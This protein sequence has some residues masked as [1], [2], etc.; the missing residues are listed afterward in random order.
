MD[1]FEIALYLSL[2]INTIQL[3]ALIIIG[4]AFIQLLNFTLKNKG[5]EESN[6]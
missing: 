1:K 5:Q 3:I 2:A 4:S 6:G